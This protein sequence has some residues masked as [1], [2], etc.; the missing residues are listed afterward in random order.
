[1]FAQP[2]LYLKFFFS[3]FLLATASGLFAEMCF[4]SAPCTSWQ[5]VY[6]SAQ[7]GNEWSQT[8]DRFT[9]RNYFNTLGSRLLGSR[10]NF[11]S[12]GCIRGGAVGYNCQRNCFV[13]GFECGTQNLNLK[14]NRASP[15]FP[16][17]D[18]YT[19]NLQWVNSAKARVGYAYKRLLSFFTGG[20]AGGTVAL[21]LT[22]TEEGVV[23]NSR[24]WANG[25]TIGAGA[26]YKIFDCLSLGLSYDYYQLSY[27]K[28]RTSCP[29]CGSGVGLGTPIVNSFLQVQTL[30]LR[31]NWIYKL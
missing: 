20:W 28:K 15:F 4:L 19:S 26:D 30:T 29:T 27:H 6:F 1:M 5:G 16:E 2:R 10:F 25:W 14:K 9:N 24:K 3:F 22:D 21:T 17:V 13:A 8:H 31:L 18:V 7:I 23:A 12:D 11:H